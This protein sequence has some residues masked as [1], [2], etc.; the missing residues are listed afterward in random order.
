MLCLAEEECTATTTGR[1]FVKV[2]VEAK[3][4]HATTT[5]T[6]GDFVKVEVETKVGHATTTTEGDFIKVG[7]EAVVEVGG[8]REERAKKKGD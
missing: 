1:D 3:V 4:G 8:G 2:E 5:T 6:G 7:V